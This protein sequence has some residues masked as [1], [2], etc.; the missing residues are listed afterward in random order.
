MHIHKQA[1]QAQIILYKYNLCC[2]RFKTLQ[3]ATSFIRILWDTKLQLFDMQLQ[4][5]H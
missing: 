1:Y 2:S 5:L 4:I 3:A